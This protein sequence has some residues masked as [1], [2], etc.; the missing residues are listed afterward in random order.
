MAG[1]L[2][3]DSRIDSLAW[4]ALVTTC[5]FIEAGG[6]IRTP[7]LLITNQPSNPAPDCT[8]LHRA[9]FLGC[10]CGPCGQSSK[11]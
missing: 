10:Q 2:I 6:E 8:R 1:A 7:D 3:I 4:L 5:V 9:V 11:L